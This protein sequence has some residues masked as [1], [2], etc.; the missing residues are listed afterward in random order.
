MEK[1]VIEILK[2]KELPKS[3]EILMN[4][5]RKIEFGPKEVKNFKK[6][7]KANDLFFFVKDKNKIIA[8]GG[9]RHVKV[10]YL[11]KKYD[12]Y[13]ICNIVAIK[14]GFGY[15]QLLL[16]A[17]INFLKKKKKTGIGFCISKISKF[18]EKAGFKVIKDLTQRFVWR[19]PKTNEIRYDKEGGDGFYIEGNDKL[20]SKLLKGKGKAY[21][22]LPDI[23]N[24]HW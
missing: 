23:K 3:Y 20:M 12:I 6:D 5:W 21:Y 16:S 4:K 14:K 18:Y 17:M 11:N 13:G 24:P 8:F 1:I 19:N 10:E 9:L 15:G 7:F 2:T 22:Y